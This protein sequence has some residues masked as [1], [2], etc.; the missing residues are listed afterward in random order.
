MVKLGLKSPLLDSSMPVSNLALCCHQEL[1]HKLRKPD[2][3]EKSDVEVEDR[4]WG[5]E[6][7]A[8]LQMVP[9]AAF[10]RLPLDEGDTKESVR[11]GHYLPPESCP[12]R[13]CQA[14]ACLRAFTHAVLGGWNHC[15]ACFVYAGCCSSI[16]T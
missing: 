6:R 9:A 15:S 1:G 4:R 12:Q 8:E 3:S 16:M 13:I 11:L 14:V 10:E 5:P 7:F 2:E